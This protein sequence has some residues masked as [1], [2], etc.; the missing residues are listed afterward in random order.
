[1]NT[2]VSSTSAL[3]LEQLWSV[4]QVC[5]FLGVKR[6]WVYAHVATKELPHVRLS[7]QCIRFVPDD[8]RRWVDSRKRQPANVLAFPGANR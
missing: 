6:T 3:T 8:V 1:M 5:H 4:D 7:G 2:S